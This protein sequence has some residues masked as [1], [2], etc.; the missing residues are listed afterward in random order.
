LK[1]RFDWRCGCEKLGTGPGIRR[2]KG[3]KARNESE[4]SI[5]AET[6]TQPIL[7]WAFVWMQMSPDAAKLVARMFIG[8]CLSPLKIRVEL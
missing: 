1:W 5:Y 2:P 8:L 7:G 3:D 6:W 4:Y